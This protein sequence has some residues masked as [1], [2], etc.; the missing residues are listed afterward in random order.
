[1]TIKVGGNR[2]RDRTA[3]NST[4]TIEPLS[5]ETMSENSYITIRN[6][7]IAGVII[8]AITTVLI[9]YVPSFFSWLGPEI[10]WYWEALIA[11]YSLPGWV[12]VVTFIFALIG[13]TTIHLYVRSQNEQPEF[14]TYIEDVIDGAKWRWSWENENISNKLWCYCPHCDAQLIPSVE[15][16]ISF[17]ETNKIVFKCEKCMDSVKASVRGED[18]NSAIARIRSEIYRRV[19]TGEYRKD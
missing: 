13:I 14:K 11:S 3:R 16:D 4:A 6:S 18:T 15:V 17:P 19:R 8:F 10:I 5:K 7:V 12:W 9:K 2:L 1:M